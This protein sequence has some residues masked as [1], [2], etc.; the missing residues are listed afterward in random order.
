MEQE[1]TR[2]FDR[3]CFDIRNSGCGFIL[4]W[5]KSSGEAVYHKVRRAKLKL[6]E[7]G[8]GDLLTRGPF[9]Y[10]FRHEF[11]DIV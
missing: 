3:I 10:K 5:W 9:V 7:H 2:I 8:E 6:S 1:D 4:P 11:A